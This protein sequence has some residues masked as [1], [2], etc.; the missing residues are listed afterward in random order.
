MTMTIEEMQNS[1]RDAVQRNPQ[2]YAGMKLIRIVQ[3]L[4]SD[5]VKEEFS[6]G[7]YGCPYRIFRMENGCKHGT[8]ATR[9]NCAKCWR[10]VYP[11]KEVA[12]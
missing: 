3:E 10:R 7:V 11:G 1:V 2:K 5:L 9:D 8:F 6:G 4:Q 12:K